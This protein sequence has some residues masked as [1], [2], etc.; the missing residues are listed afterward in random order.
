VAL[1]IRT[2]RAAGSALL[3]AVAVGAGGMT[4]TG[5]A[6]A[7]DPG[8]VAFGGTLV[9]A[10]GQPLGGV[11]LTIV[12]ELPPDGGIAAFPVTTAD[13][14]TF[15]ADLYAWGTAAA[16]ASVT[17]STEPDEEL[18][19]E[20]D[21]CS[22]TWSVAASERLEIALT[23]SAPDELRVTAITELLGEVCGT[24]GTPGGGSGDGG[25]NAG[26]SAGVTPPP[27]DARLGATGG[28]R[29][30]RL[31]PALWV[32][33]GLGLV[34]ALAVFVPSRGSRRRS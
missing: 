31:G 7:A 12:E 16:P 5:S 15:A 26:G 3:V 27:T 14:G 30:D 1:S 4:G 2:I 28:A 8:R 32:G 19:V 34:I 9:D 11:R 6:L 20:R 22:Q 25:A 21:S 23:E 13:D 18:M 10:A 29:A 33:F 24:T 17:V